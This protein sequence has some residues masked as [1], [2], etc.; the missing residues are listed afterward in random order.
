MFQVT[1]KVTG[2][3]A[4]ISDRCRKLG[5]HIKSRRRGGRNGEREKRRTSPWGAGVGSLWFNLWSF[6]GNLW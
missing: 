2:E 5:E 6:N 4:E 1:A 3:E